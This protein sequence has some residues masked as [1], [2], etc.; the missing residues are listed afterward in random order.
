[1]S[2]WILIWFRDS[3]KAIRKRNSK[4]STR[5]RRV[6]DEN[7]RNDEFIKEEKRRGKFDEH[8]VKN[9]AEKIRQTSETEWWSEWK[10]ILFLFFFFCSNRMTEI[11]W[12]V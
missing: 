1:M 2:L 5:N 11:H 7:R 9:I 4:I 3:I 10:M 12:N 8:D 6:W